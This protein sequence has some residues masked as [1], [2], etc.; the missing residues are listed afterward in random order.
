MPERKPWDEDDYD[1][2]R[3][4]RFG[5]F[6][7]RRDAPG[8]AVYGPPLAD[9][10]VRLLARIIDEL[11]GTVASLPGIVCAVVGFITYVNDRGRTGAGLP[12]IFGGIALYVCLFGALLI[13]Q[14]I[15]LSK[16][17][18][19]I[20]KWIMKV[21][22]VKYEDGSHAG[23]VHA[24]LLRNCVPYMISL[25]GGLVWNLIDILFIFGEEQRC[26]HDLIAS[27]KVVE[28]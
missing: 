6:G 27:T 19:S 12:W 28:A 3:P 7:L 17:G 4:E 21:R 20:G 5:E 26:V 25:V 9:R 15:Q 11:L 16:H 24:W 10:G 18:Q 2:D 8:G 23:F 14:I 22:V 13:Y 1:E